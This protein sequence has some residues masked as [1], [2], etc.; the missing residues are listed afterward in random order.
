[1]N[2]PGLQRLGLRSKVGAV[3]PRSVFPSGSLRGAERPL[4]MQF[5]GGLWLAFS[6]RNV[7]VQAPSIAAGSSAWYG[8]AS[9]SIPD[10]LPQAALCGYRI[11]AGPTNPTPAADADYSSTANMAAWGNTSGTGAALVIGL[12]LPVQ[13]GAWSSGPANV[14]FV[15]PPGAGANTTRSTATDRLIFH[16]APGKLEDSP[17]PMIYRSN[18]STPVAVLLPAGARL[19]VALVVRR[20]SV[21]GVVKSIGIVGRVYG[22]LLVASTLTRGDFTE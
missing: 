5:P 1:M 6:M 9:W 4:L 16:F 14:P 19:D 22:E 17:L 11:E 18:Q 10:D 12:N 2:V 13:A 20:S 3:P 7:P 21:H 8:L 15:E